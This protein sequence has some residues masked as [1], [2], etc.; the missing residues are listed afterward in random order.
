MKRK[1]GVS[2]CIVLLLSALLFIRSGRLCGGD[3]GNPSGT[4][5]PAMSD[6]GKGETSSPEEAAM[7]CSTIPR[8]RRAIQSPSAVL[9][10]LLGGHRPHTGNPV[11]TRIFT[12]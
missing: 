8:L 4:D 2:T 9:R 11:E 1:F 3:G 6:T 12:T 5:T 10:E 7:R